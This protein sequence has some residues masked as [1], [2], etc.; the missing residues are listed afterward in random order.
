MKKI[1][2]SIMLFSIL[3]IQSCVFTSE[4]TINT[5]TVI[6]VALEFDDIVLIIEKHKEAFTEVDWIKLQQSKKDLQE[7][8]TII[9]T[10]GVASVS[11]LS[12]IRDAIKQVYTEVR[13]IINVNLPKFTLKERIQ[14]LE[15]D[16]ELGNIDSMITKLEIEPS[17]E[18][19]DKVISMLLAL[20]KTILVILPLII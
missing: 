10:T 12:I 7:V 19:T 11:Q 20:S 5:S 2:L 15:F 3:F 13:V 8:S 4:N 18:N 17:E 16:R 1:I 6:S 9:Q 14:L